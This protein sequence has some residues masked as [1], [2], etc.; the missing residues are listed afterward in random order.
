[1]GVLVLGM[2]RSGTS[3]LAG[4]L[5]AMGFE[6][7]PSDD[8]MEGDEGNPQGYFEL[9]SIAALNDE[10]LAHYR[11]R[12]D[13]PPVVAPGWAHDDASMQFASRARDALTE[14][15]ESE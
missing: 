3:A 13:S 15:Y 2:H 10:V 14:L 8:L 5:E 1:M 12:W 6:A 9:R 11:G 4:A 7:G